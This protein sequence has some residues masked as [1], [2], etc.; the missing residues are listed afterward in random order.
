[1]KKICIIFIIWNCIFF[2]VAC[3]GEMIKRK[4]EDKNDMT[5]S[6][7]EGFN[8]GNY[9]FNAVEME[10]I[11]IGERDLRKRKKCEMVTEITEGEIQNFII[12]RDDIGE[13]ISM[14]I[15]SGSQGI[16]MSSNLGES[17]DEWGGAKK[18]F[19][20]QMATCDFNCDGEK[21]I[22]IGAGN[23]RDVLELYI[24][25][26]KKNLEYG[27][28]NPKL[29]TKIK[30]GYKAYLNKERKICVVDEKNNLISRHELG[31]QDIN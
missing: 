1:M 17:L 31:K 21:E 26:I 4:M 30:G 7:E 28:E 23:K 12:K 8:E 18:G 6:Q 10:S 24:F 11:E 14:I 16:D 25:Q 29:I 27:E 5:L 9:L 15:F 22:I 3:S 2:L 13:G 20:Y 19:F